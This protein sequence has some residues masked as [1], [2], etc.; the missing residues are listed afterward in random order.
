MYIKQRTRS[1][2]CLLLIK[3]KATPSNTGVQIRY[4]SFQYEI[5]T[6]KTQESAR[7]K[8][9]DERMSMQRLRA[10]DKTALLELIVQIITI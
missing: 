7:V 8:S 9:N 10:N 5:V 3:T 6:R 4:H 2:I 1:Q